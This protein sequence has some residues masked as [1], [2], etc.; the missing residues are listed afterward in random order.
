MGRRILVIDDYPRLAEYLVFGLKRLGYDARGATDGAAALRIVDEFLPQVSLIDLSLPG[1]SGYEVARYIRHQAWGKNSW[2]IGVTGFVSEEERL[3]MAKAGF[4]QWLI[5]PVTV[6]DI[7][8][9]L[10]DF[11]L[12][13][14]ASAHPPSQQQ[15]G[16]LPVIYNDERSVPTVANLPVVFSGVRR[17]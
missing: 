9:L 10:R 11:D 5:K 14:T 1:I 8:S 6:A 12:P 3:L 16:E 4:D 15:A 13:D 2:L 17:P 7:L